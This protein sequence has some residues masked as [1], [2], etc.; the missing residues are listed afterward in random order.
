LLRLGHAHAGKNQWAQAADAYRRAC[1][2]D[3]HEPVPLYLRGWA[4]TK[5]GQE[6]EGRKLIDLAHQLPLGNEEIRYALAEAL[7]ERGLAEESRR[8]LEFI[9]RIGGFQSLSLPNALGRLTDDAL[10]RKDYLQAAANLERVVLQCLRIRWG[11]VKTE[12]YLL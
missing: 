1:E 6:A 4:L 7:R 5:A 3:P 12:G 2:K 8:E 10:A 11:F 9:V